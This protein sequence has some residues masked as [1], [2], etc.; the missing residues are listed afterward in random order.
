MTC[1]FLKNDDFPP[2]WT[3]CI[4]NES[5]N[6]SEFI[7]A[8][9]KY[10]CVW[11]FLKKLDF[12]KIFFSIFDGKKISIA[13]FSKIFFYNPPIF[14]RRMILNTENGNYMKVWPSWRH[15]ERSGKQSKLLRADSTPPTLFRVNK[16][17]YIISENFTGK[18]WVF[19]AKILNHSICNRVS[20][21]KHS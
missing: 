6:H 3:I 16:C 20:I 2:T 5:W 4:S 14:F 21:L 8:V 9:K 11:N 19:D 17:T 15:P 12:K 7:F 18:Y 13:N 10:Y 1:Q